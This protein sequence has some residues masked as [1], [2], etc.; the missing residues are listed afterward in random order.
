LVDALYEVCA[1]VVEIVPDLQFN[2]LDVNLSAPNKEAAAQLLTVLAA[3]QKGRLDFFTPLESPSLTSAFVGRLHRHATKT[4][5]LLALAKAAAETLG[6]SSGGGSGGVAREVGV[7]ARRMTTRPSQRLP[8]TP[9]TMPRDS[10][11]R[12]GW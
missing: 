7:G 3:S 5:K 4:L 11:T 1:V 2:L 8:T 9:T 12:R 6:A 10:S